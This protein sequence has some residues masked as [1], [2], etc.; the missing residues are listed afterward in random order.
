VAGWS[1]GS[2]K[3]IEFKSSVASTFP[4]CIAKYLI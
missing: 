1:G 3:S 2:V 4:N